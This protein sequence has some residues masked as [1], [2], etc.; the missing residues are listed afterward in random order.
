MAK[1]II[2]KCDKCGSTAETDEAK[3]ELGLGAITIGFRLEQSTYSGPIVHAAHQEWSREWCRN[4]RKKMGILEYQRGY[5]TV[6][7]NP[8]TIEDMIRA[9]VQE[10]LPQQ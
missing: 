2:E 8:P 9:I 4:C 3:R 7:D 5:T 6:V 1:I 10:E